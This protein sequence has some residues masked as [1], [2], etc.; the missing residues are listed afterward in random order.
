[1]PSITDIAVVIRRWDF[2]ETSQTV[3]LFTREHG[4]VRGIA[5]GAKRE[6]G[7]FSGGLDVLTRGQVVAIVKP[8]RDL[9]TLTAWHLQETYRVLRQ[10]LDANRAGLYMADLV[11]HLLTDHDPHPALFDAL[12]TALTTLAR[13]T[14][15][16][17]VL[18]GLQWRLLEEVGYRPEL[19]R[20]V[21]TGATLDG[22]D[23]AMFFSA[24]AGGVTGSASGPACWRVRPGTID[25]LRTAARRAPVADCD[26]RSVDRA[27]R[28]LAAYCRELVGAEIPAMRWAFSDL[29]AAAERDAADRS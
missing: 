17:P 16:G 10:R 5:K 24:R 22:H 11:H 29:D 19:D 18:L 21:E 1:M 7:M 14:D 12:D 2:S 4:I 9:A 27:N 23:A 28:L 6:R 15:C 3:S 13:V 8:G 25:V 26:P 20:D